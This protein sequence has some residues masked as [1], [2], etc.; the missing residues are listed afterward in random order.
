MYWLLHET[1]SQKIG[2]VLKLLDCGRVV[3]SYI[4]LFKRARGPA[5]FF[6]N[7]L[8]VVGGTVCFTIKKYKKQMKLNLR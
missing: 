7:T 1:H 8:I 3:E 5:A 2:T 4:S 6:F